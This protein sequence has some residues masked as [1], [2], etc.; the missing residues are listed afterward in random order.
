MSARPL[1]G[2]GE[3]QGGVVVFRDV[4]QDRKMQQELIQRVKKIEEQN[5]EIV[6]FLTSQNHSKN[7][8]TSL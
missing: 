5:Q 3:N 7:L 6:S 2:N 4:T 8:P 1:Q